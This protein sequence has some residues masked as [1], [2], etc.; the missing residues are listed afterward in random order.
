[1]RPTLGILFVLSIFLSC[2]EE[3]PQYTISTSADP[4]EG[5][6]I[7]PAS[8][9]HDEGTQL[10]F[11][12]TP[13]DGYHF[14]RWSGALTGTSNPQAHTLT[15]D[16][17]VTAHF[18]LT[19]TIPPVITLDP[20]S[21]L[22]NQGDP[23]TPPTVTAT[24]DV[25]GDLTESIVIGGDTVDTNTLGTYV[26]RYNVSD[27]AGNAAAERTHTVVVGDNFTPITDLTLSTNNVEVLVNNA[28]TPITNIVLP[29]GAT[30]AYSISPAL[31]DGLTLDESSGEISGTPTVVSSNEYT[32]TASGTGSYS[33][34]QT[35][36]LVIVTKETI[37][38]SKVTY[39]VAK[40]PVVEIDLSDSAYVDSTGALDFVSLA[41][42]HGY[43]GGP[44]VIGTIILGEYRASSNTTNQNGVKYVAFKKGGRT[45]T[46]M[47]D[48]E[49]VQP[50]Y[51][52]FIEFIA[53]SSDETKYPT[54]GASSLIV[55]TLTSQDASK[56]ATILHYG[57]DTSGGSISAQEVAN[58]Y[59]KTLVL[60][61][62][63]DMSSEDI[64]IPSNADTSM[65][66]TNI[67]TAGGTVGIQNLQLTINADGS[68][69]LEADEDFTLEEK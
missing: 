10:S 57:T 45:G 21:Q 17:S 13:N 1:M 53:E 65:I 22:I 55:A 8:G 28:I 2:V 52:L 60:T 31:P 68:I 51:N 38:F 44:I 12:A 47:T 64:V 58:M 29:T 56:D 6:T 16:V 24:D 20:L 26:I 5:G 61:K 23:Y 41:L 40:G 62:S 46:E 18:A 15:Q 48:G 7:S 35:S 11:E 39:S 50:S 34:V 67:E 32:V 9:T 49:T 42:T 63:S 14:E 43:S 25:D 19:D 59:G 37:P 54:K 30:V 3:T 33:G 66:K 4:V 69:D 27:A 36:S